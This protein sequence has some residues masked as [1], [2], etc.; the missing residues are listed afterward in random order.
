M[1]IAIIAFTNIEYTIELTEALSEL[2]DVMLMLPDNQ[3][4]RFRQIIGA[5]VNL[6][7]FYYPRIRSLKNILMSYRLVQK[8][9]SFNPDIIHIQRGHPWFNLSLPFLK[10][11]CI[12][13][14]IH[15]VI[16]HTGDLESRIIPK[17]THKLAIRY[18]D[19][20]IV[21]GEALKKEMMK[22]Y[23]K[24][25]DEISV[26]HRGINSIYRRYVETKI[27]EM[28]HTVLF[29][30][31]IWGYKGLQYLIEA[32]PRITREIPNFKIIIAGRGED[33]NKMYGDKMVN[34]D[35]YVIHNKHIPNA[36]VAE[37]FQK[38]SVVVLPYTDASQSGVVPLAYAFGK[39]V[40]VTNVG[41]LPEV[42][43]DGETG[44]IV[45]PK[46]SNKLGDAIIELLKNGAKRKR[47][48][49]KAYRKGEEELSWGR[50]A[51]RTVEVYKKAIQLRNISK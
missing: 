49:E 42:V 35:R 10:R 48:G 40:V 41:S 3:A 2:E 30:G 38:A 39:P 20:I 12:I 7:A 37:L 8:I 15:D 11:Y 34:K 32:E 31:R 44:F 45:P 47:M 21:H 36:M 14:T 23:S 6:Y 27:E 50:I 29:F 24:K 51:F 22:E 19:Q 16:L 5:N 28:D 13:T 1:R 18:C 33:V 46:D 17:F 25:P 4:E 9:N 26:L 43:D